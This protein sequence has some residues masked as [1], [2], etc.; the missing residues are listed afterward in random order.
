MSEQVNLV[1]V[2]DWALARVI[3]VKDVT[4][5]YAYLEKILDIPP[6]S[7][8][9]FEDARLVMQRQT[10]RRQWPRH[11][12][13]MLAAQRQMNTA[14]LRSAYTGEELVATLLTEGAI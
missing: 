10:P 13:F 4:F 2:P 3:G 8:I 6:S 11:I 7:Y 14:I 5:L 12:V 1:G 9:R